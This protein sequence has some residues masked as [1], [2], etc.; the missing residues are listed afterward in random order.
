MAIKIIIDMTTTIEMI[1]AAVASPVSADDWLDMLSW[2]IKNLE[3]YGK[4]I[5]KMPK[6]KPKC[7]NTAAVFINLR[8]LI[9]PHYN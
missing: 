5:I 8:N 7:K 3:I 9:R 4:R 1:T 2:F 6:C